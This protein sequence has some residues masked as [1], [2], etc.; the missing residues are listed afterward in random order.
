MSRFISKE[1]LQEL[2]GGDITSIGGDFIAT[3]DSEIQTGPVNKP[4]NDDSEYEKGMPTTTDKVFGHYRQ[5]IPWFAVYS[6]G[7]SN[8]GGLALNY[9]SINRIGLNENKTIIKKKTV[10]EKIEDLVKRSKTSDVTDKN[11][12][13]KVAKLIDTINDVDLTDAQLDDLSK[14]ILHKKNNSKPI[15]NL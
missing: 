8:T 14:A 4:F 13:P 2:V 7:G 12:N 15:K 3:N 11:Y 9:G 10:E 5:N 1:R 6:F